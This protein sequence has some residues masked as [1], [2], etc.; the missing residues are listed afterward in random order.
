MKE[1]GNKPTA[2]ALQYDGRQAPRVTAKGYGEVA[3]EII[4]LARE[5]NIPLYE[6]VE[7]VGLLS[8]LDLGDEIP[9]ALYIAVARVIAF[10]Y[11]LAGKTAPFAD[12]PSA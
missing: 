12:D 6:D 2:V 11:L 3:E 7:L 10:A 5:H 4:R 1:S 8:R 9:E